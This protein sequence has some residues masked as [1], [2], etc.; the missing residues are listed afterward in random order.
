MTHVAA[1]V[2]ILGLCL[3][4]ALIAGVVLKAGEIDSSKVTVGAYVLCFRRKRNFLL[5][6]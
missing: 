1:I 2:L 5:F 4:Q 6:E 3:P